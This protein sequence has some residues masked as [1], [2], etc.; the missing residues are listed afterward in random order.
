M[1]GKSK[2]VS[3]L[4]KDEKLSLIEKENVWILWSGETVVWVLGIRQDD[5]FKV[6]DTTQNILKI[7]LE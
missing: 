3:K 4:F 5:R 7:Q 2:K 6:S 1:G